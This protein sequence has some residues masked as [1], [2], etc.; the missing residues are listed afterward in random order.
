MGFDELLDL[1]IFELVVLHALQIFENLPKI[2]VQ[3]SQNNNQTA[4]IQMFEIFKF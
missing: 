3:V 4:V 1:M 2:K